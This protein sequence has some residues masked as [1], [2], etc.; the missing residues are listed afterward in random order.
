MFFHN[1]DKVLSNKYSEFMTGFL[2]LEIL[3]EKVEV[4]FN[5]R[6][7]PNKTQLNNSI[8]QV[9]VRFSLKTEGLLACSKNKCCQKI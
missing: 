3:K 8:Y 7:K 2:E 1:L 9:L 4:L 5:I 6:K